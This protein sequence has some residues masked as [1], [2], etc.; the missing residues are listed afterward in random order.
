MTVLLQGH[1]QIHRIS[2]VGFIERLEGD[3]ADAE[4]KGAGVARDGLADV[5]GVECHGTPVSSGAGLFGRQQNRTVEDAGDIGLIHDRIQIEGKRHPKLDRIVIPPVSAECQVSAGHG[6]A[7]DYRD[8]IQFVHDQ[9]LRGINQ[10]MTPDELIEYVKLPT[11]LAQSPYLQEFYGKVSWSARSMFNGNLGWF[12]GDSADLQPLSPVAQAGMMEEIAG[13]ESKLLQFARKYLDGGNHPAALQLS[14]HII[15]LNPKNKE[16]RDIRVTALSALG[17]REFNANAHHYYL[18]EAQEIRDD[19][20]VQTKIKPDPQMIRRFPLALFFDFMA[21]NLDPIKSADLDKLVGIQFIDTGEA[22]TIHV[23]RG[24][25]EI[26]P[27]I[28]D[29][30]DILVRADSIKW[31]GMLLKRRNPLTT[32][33]GFDYPKDNAVAFAGF[34]RNFEAMPM[35]RPVESRH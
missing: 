35:Q 21:V 28:K 17:E 6:L 32:L 16:A 34:L 3:A 1:V 4:T 30:L 5:A 25:A 18:T 23:R 22:F 13:G 27:V 2:P 14:G 9:S 26:K 33:A 8:A 10:G 12:S 29:N 31:K 19:F 11:H 7:T 24:V 15:R 20:V